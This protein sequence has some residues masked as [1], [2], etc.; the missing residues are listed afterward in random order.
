MSANTADGRNY[1]GAA[2]SF[3]CS[4]W[5]WPNGEAIVGKRSGERNLEAMRGI[6]TTGAG[7]EQAVG[8]DA[9]GPQCRP[10][11][12]YA[13]FC[14]P[15]R[16]CAGQIPVTCGYAPGFVAMVMNFRKRISATGDR[17]TNSNPYTCSFSQRTVASSTVIGD[18]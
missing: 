15:S 14:A 1:A 4:Y 16:Y 10:D 6:A 9:P 17:S 5:T 12:G 3:V 18:T 8:T 2:A 13:Q 11:R 7:E